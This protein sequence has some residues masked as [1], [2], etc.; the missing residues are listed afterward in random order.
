MSVEIFVQ[1]IRQK[2]VSEYGFYID[3]E[4]NNGLY[5]EIHEHF[6]LVFYHGGDA[7]IPIFGFWHGD[8]KQFS[9]KQKSKLTRLLQREEF[10]YYLSDFPDWGPEWIVREIIIKDHS[11]NIDEFVQI[12]S[13]RYKLLEIEVNAIN[14]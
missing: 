9:P 1:S 8:D 6:F 2:L 4:D 10:S 3:Q 14:V 11:D 7:K 5:K 12:I 13:E